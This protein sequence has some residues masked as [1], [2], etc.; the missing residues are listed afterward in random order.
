MVIQWTRGSPGIL[1]LPGLTKI[2]QIIDP[3]GVVVETSLRDCYHVVKVATVQH[4]GIWLARYNLYGMLEPIEQ[5]IRIET[6][7]TTPISTNV[8]KR[9]DLR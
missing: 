3:N 5:K 2:C 4:E 6:L 9:L 8:R 1:S 7:G